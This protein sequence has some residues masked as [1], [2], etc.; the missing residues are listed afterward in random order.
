MD[1]E[2]YKFLS[3]SLFFNLKTNY[4]VHIF[5]CKIIK[6][7]VDMQVYSKYKEYEVLLL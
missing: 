1:V 3:S 5:K 7:H 4:M 6:T 2:I